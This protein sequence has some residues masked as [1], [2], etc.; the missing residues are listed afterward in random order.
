MYVGEIFDWPAALTVRRILKGEVTLNSSSYSHCHMLLFFSI[1]RYGGC[2]FL[3]AISAVN[4]SSFGI[5]VP[6]IYELHIFIMLS[7]N[8]FRAMLKQLKLLPSLE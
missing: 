2:L 7:A 4:V 8:T 5:K 6:D 3:N 1:A